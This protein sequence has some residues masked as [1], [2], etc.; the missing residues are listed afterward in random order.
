MFPRRLA[1]LF[2]NFRGAQ[3]CRF[4]AVNGNV[5][6]YRNHGKQRLNFVTSARPQRDYLQPI[7][8][9]KFK[10]ARA[11]FTSRK[12]VRER[13]RPWPVR[14]IRVLFKVA[15]MIFIGSTARASV[16]EVRRGFQRAR[17]AMSST[18][19]VVIF[20]HPSIRLPLSIS[21][22]CG[23]VLKGLAIFRHGRGK[24]HL[25]NEAQ[26]R[27][28]GRNVI[29]CLMMT[30]IYALHRICSNLRVA[31]DR[32][33]RSGRARVYV[34]NFGL[35]RRHFLYDVLR[36]GVGNDCCVVTVRQERVRCVRPFISG[37]NAIKL[38]NHATRGAIV[39]RFRPV[40][41]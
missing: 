28:I 27:R 2:R 10:A 35:L 32:F 18:A 36:K 19:P 5:M 40:A 1:I 26:L 13:A 30:A 21:Y 25:R 39:S 12:R 3:A 14:A 33:R 4:S 22:F 9:V 7:A 15:P 29:I 41:N 24:D 37:L 11:Q 31:H 17:A 20:R 8:T 38:S 16:K 6:R 34:S 23:V